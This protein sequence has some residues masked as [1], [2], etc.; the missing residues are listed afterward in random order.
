MCVFLIVTLPCR[1]NLYALETA[2][3][4]ELK[5]EL[6]RT[7]LREESMTPECF[8]FTPLA[9]LVIEK[10]LPTNDQ[11]ARMTRLHCDCWTTL[12]TVATS[13]QEATLWRDIFTSMLSVIDRF[14]MLIHFGDPNDPFQIAGPEFRSIATS[15]GLMCL[16]WDTLYEIGGR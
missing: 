12:G 16:Q 5:R 3:P 9:N 2:I 1:A 10:Q 4:Q 15:T 11:L 6:L 13:E 7:G 14:G 8:G